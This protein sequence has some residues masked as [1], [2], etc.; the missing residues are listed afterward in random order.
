MAGRCRYGSQPAS[1]AGVL[2]AGSTQGAHIASYLADLAA[3]DGQVV[4]HK[5]VV[6]LAEVAMPL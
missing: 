1:L 6:A 4:A 3:A 2:L 5:R